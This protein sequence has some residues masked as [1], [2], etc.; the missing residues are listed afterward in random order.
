M[1]APHRPHQLLLF[2]PPYRMLVPLSSVGAVRLASDR[3]G[4][5]LIWCMGSRED[6]D[7]LA[8]LR[9]RPGGLPLFIVLPRIDEVDRPQDLFRLV[10]YCRPLTMLPYHE[11]PSPADLR[12]LLARKPSD[13]PGAMVECLQ[14]RG[15]PMDSDLKH[16][17]RRVVEMSTEVRTVSGLARGLYMSRRALARRFL[18]EG[19]PVPSHWLHISRLIRVSLSLQAPGATLMNVAFEHGYPDG[20]SLSN[21]MK[22][23]TG[24]RPSQV[25]P[26]L[27]WEWILEEW[28]QTEIREGGFRPDQVQLL[29]R[30]T[31]PQGEKDLEP[32]AAGQGDERQPA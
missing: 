4:G 12:T 15:L 16:I 8:A 27:G 11:E 19:L 20:F 3:Q 17:L 30:R 13:L 23:L 25:I 2:R 28:L 29:Q 22:R 32:E 26:R 14:W 24:L 5:A 31:R 7:L 10:E 9:R 6:P 18:R 21:Q 1:S